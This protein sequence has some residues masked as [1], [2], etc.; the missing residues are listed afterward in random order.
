MSLKIE[1]ATESSGVSRGL[2]ADFMASLSLLSLRALVKY[3]S[4][5]KSGLSKMGFPLI[6]PKV[7]PK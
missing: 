2:K 5:C 4:V 7:V 3:Q 1:A 6:P